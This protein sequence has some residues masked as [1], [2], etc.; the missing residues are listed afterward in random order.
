[1]KSAAIA[2]DRSIA[3]A[4]DGNQLGPRVLAALAIV[5]QRRTDRGDVL[6]GYAADADTP[7]VAV[8]LSLG[9]DPSFPEL[10]DRV[11]GALDGNPS[12]PAPPAGA[13]PFDAVVTVG[14]DPPDETKH[15]VW[16]V[17]RES[18][19]GVQLSFHDN[20]SAT[21]EDAVAGL[22]GH[23]QTLLEGPTTDRQVPVSALSML[24]GAELDQLLVGFNDTAAPYP[25]ACFHELF[26]RQARETA[27]SVA[28]V[29][30]EQRLTYGELDARANQLA[31]HLVAIGVGPEVL[32]GIAVQRSAEMLVGLLGIL[33]AGGA[34]VPVDPAYPAERQEFMLRSSGAAVVVTEERL[35]AGL[36]LAG[37]TVVCLDRDWP[38]IG[39]LGSEP[40]HVPSDPEQ[41][42][43]V[44]YTSGSTGQPKG[45]QISHRALV[46]FLTTMGDVPG[47]AGDDVLVAVTTLSFDIA[48]LEL[49]LPLLVG[50]QVVVAPGETVSDP[51]AL[52]RLLED[53]AAT[54]MQATPTTWRMLLD[55]GW[56][57]S[58]PLKALCGGEPLPVAL[59]DRL[60]SLDIELWNMYGPTETTIWSTCAR[61]DT[62]GQTLTIGRPIAN[63]TLYILDKHRRPVPVGVAG[64]LWIGGDGLARGYRGRPDLTEERFIPDPLDATDGA[65]I[66]R[67][68]DLARYR[69]DG[70]VEFL[71]RID[72]QVKVRG[73]R[74][75]LGEIET[76]LT[77]HPGVAEAVVVARGATG[78]E[79]ELAAY[80]IPEQEPVPAHVLREFAGNTLPTYM[81]PSTVTTLEAFPLTPNGKIDR[82]A[83]P[84]PTRERSAERE[85]VAAETEL[86]RRLTAIWERELEISPI[87]AT[88][89]FFDLGVTSVVAATLFAAIEHELGNELPLGAIFQAPTIRALARLLQASG[90]SSRWTSLIPIQTEGSRPP[91]F[92][93]H[94]GAG[95]ILHLAAL[96]RRLGS[97]Q[98][99]YGLQARG[100]YGGASPLTTV[101]EMATHYLS[102]MRQVQPQGPWYLAG[103]CFGSIV[104][105]EIAQRLRAQGEEVKLLAVFNGPSP[106]W[107]KRWGWHG[108]QP[109]WLA[110]H[111][112]PPRP[113]TQ[114]LRRSR[115]A[116][117]RIRLA[118][119]IRDPRRFWTGLMWDLWEPRTRVALALRRP[120]P[121]QL[122]EKYFLELHSKAERAYLPTPFDG[123]MIV[124]YSENLYED[125]TL[126]WAGLAQ[127]GVDTFAV[128]GEHNGN[129]E[130]MMEPAVELVA[131][132]LRE[133]L[134]RL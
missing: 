106:A 20:A 81:I 36:P 13:L 121:E 27:D 88:D 77:R 10:M 107:I 14:Q 132:R 92:C 18:S 71:G 46:N 33:K 74:I 60:T 4:D 45:V 118:R 9:D 109:G 131:E 65:R 128:A 126:G 57:P 55:A 80:V 86:E 31:R 24:T 11:A 37:V 12:P 124:F 6:L 56:K 97:D 35:V 79:A 76:V 95:T 3:N 51:R 62:R 83:L 61:V 129:R 111:P 72:N 108:N 69:P 116:T 39:Q 70:A 105:F 52:A 34:Y 50:A 43:Y 47:L 48:G 99:F 28:V 40:V 112:R 64:E 54:V 53:C 2:A 26:E 130:A 29:S 49:Y 98:P 96:S 103:Y 85:L 16:L 67:T 42:A 73:F 23:L 104:A 1:M 63:T 7:V 115:F 100:L 84:E 90:E 102:E 58:R 122:R 127:G 113:T 87:G 19:G 93:V 32:V 89:N 8:T 94:G 133:R 117:Q 41:L 21:G 22:L 75:E 17:A 15:P 114:Q 30:G 78:A 91:V 82:Q 134:D 125:P 44:I 110:N 59:A 119:A 120:I 101:P 66:Y 123:E 68:G 25:P 38:L 5:L